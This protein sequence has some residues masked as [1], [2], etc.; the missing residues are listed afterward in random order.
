MEFTEITVAGLPIENGINSLKTLHVVS[1]DL[2]L[3]F[4]NSSL[5]FHFAKIKGLM[6]KLRI[7]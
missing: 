3:V 1:P 6:D 5:S 4:S 2:L 7:N